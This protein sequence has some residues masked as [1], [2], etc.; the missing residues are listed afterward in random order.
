MGQSLLS[1]VIGSE[2]KQ[3]AQREPAVQQRDERTSSDD[4]EEDFEMIS[5]D[6][7]S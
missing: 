7:L 4:S 5:Q 1:T 6:D 3:K 2:T